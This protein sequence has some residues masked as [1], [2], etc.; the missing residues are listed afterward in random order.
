LSLINDKANYIF[1]SNGQCYLDVTKAY[2]DFGYTPG[3]CG[4]D[5][6]CKYGT[7]QDKPMSFFVNL[8]LLVGEIGTWYD[9]NANI[10]CPDAG[11]IPLKDL[12]WVKIDQ[13]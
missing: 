12:L 11:L 7:F 2:P 10:V 4:T 1:Q 6:L 3:A 5:T 13:N 8:S 9:N